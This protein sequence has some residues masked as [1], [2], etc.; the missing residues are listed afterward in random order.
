MKYY[1]R[2]SETAE[3]VR[4]AIPAALGLN[5]LSMPLRWPADSEL[6]RGLF[7]FFFFVSPRTRAAQGC[8][9][10][11]AGSGLLMTET[12]EARGKVIA[13]IHMCRA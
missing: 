12:N 11:T 9:I 13:D 6:E 2:N 1:A 4:G 10:T 3:H 8:M 7:F 5:A